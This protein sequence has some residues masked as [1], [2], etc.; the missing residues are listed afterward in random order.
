MAELKRGSNPNPSSRPDTESP[1]GDSAE[2]PRR[3]LSQRLRMPLSVEA[4]VDELGYDDAGSTSADEEDTLG[5]A[6]SP[7]G[8]SGE[9]VATDWHRKPVQR[10]V[11]GESQLETRQVAGK[12][13]ATSSEGLL[14]TG[15]QLQNRYKVLGVIGVGGMAVVYK[16]QDLRFPGVMRLCAIKEMINTAADPQ[17]RQ[18]I[19]RNFEREASILATLSHPA[20][21]Q[22][23]DYFT[24]GSR[25][26]LV[27][28][29]IPGKDLEARVSEI[30]GFFPETQVIEWAVQ[31]CDVLSYL[32]NHKPRPI[33]FR[34]FKPSNIILDTHGRIR[35]VDFG[36]AKLFQSGQKGTMI[37]T[38]GYSPPE[39]YRGVAEPRGDVYALGATLHHLLSKQDPRLEPP[40]SFKERPI[41]MT[42]PTASRE[43]VTVVDRALEYD[44][45]ERWGSAE[46]FRRA[47]LL[48]PAARGLSPVKGEST[49]MLAGGAVKPIWRF[50]C[51]DEVRGSVTLTEEVVVAPSYDHNVYALGIDDGKFLWKYAAEGG[52]AASP[53]INDELVV[54]GS[55]DQNVYAVDLAEGQLVWMTETKGRIYSSAQAQFGHFFVGSD[56]GHLYAI[57][58]TSGRKAWSYSADSEIRSRPFV[59]DHLV[60]FSCHIGLVYALSLGRELRWRFRARRGIIA[61]PILSDGLVFVGSLD[62]TF[63]ALDSRSGWAA[64]KYR[65]GGP[66]ASTAAIWDD[67]VIF[68]SADGYIYALQATDGRVVWRYQTDGQVTG[69]ATVY[70]GAVYVGGVDGAFYCLDA[71]TGILRWRYQTEGAITGAPTA[72][73]G[74]IYFGSGDHYVYALPA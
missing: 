46:E 22:V 27:E 50:A 59:D 21:P 19:V 42:N 60:I 52:I 24:E 47:L 53:C 37:G 49:T 54:F 40:F 13:A 64:W 61:S 66:V 65:T 62:W 67:L 58:G 2:K 44:V 45:N 69:S 43:L 41:H 39:Q 30:E 12:K 55:T 38:E 8:A 32:H 15:T 1:F 73:D 16:A 9:P 29:F 74:I 56:D 25:S 4:N 10:V 70:E 51:E 48:V 23:Y 17:V 34:D 26:Y 35:L 68:G 11:A 14:P 18:M 36:I 6:A 31:L 33:I 72:A 71:Q 7:D 63:Y 28:E 3:G 57:H 20:I 5:D